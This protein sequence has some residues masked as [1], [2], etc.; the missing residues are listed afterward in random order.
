MGTSG[1]GEQVGSV[2]V[3]PCQ[4]GQRVLVSSHEGALRS[5]WVGSDGKVFLQVIGD[6]EEPSHMERG[7]KG[8]SDTSKLLE[9]DLG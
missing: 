9:R 7:K 5:C 1:P 4:G 2:L 3:A 8:I 6:L